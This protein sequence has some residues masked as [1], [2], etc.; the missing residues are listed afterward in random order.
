[1]TDIIST[2]RFL[3]KISI[4]Y[5]ETK[6][7]KFAKA[8]YERYE[9]A[10]IPLLYALDVETGIGYIQPNDNQDSNKISWSKVDEILLN[11]ILQSKVS[12]AFEIT[13]TDEDFK[14]FKENWDDQQ[15]TIGF[16]VELLKDWCYRYIHYCRLSPKYSFLQKD[17]LVYC[18]RLLF[19]CSIS[20]GK[21]QHHQ[22]CLQQWFRYLH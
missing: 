19:H 12:N 5:G 11:K 16:M 13:L 15:D 6:L 14:D 20:I 22:L 9:D 21:E 1:M 10:E 3:N 18:L 4:K 8:F 7:E 2:A 17:C